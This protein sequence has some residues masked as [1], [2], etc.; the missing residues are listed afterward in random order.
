MLFRSGLDIKGV[1]HIYNYNIPKISNDYIHRIGRTARAG[2]EGKV[3]N[4]IS[5]EDYM[6]FRGIM[7][8]DLIKA[9]MKKEDIPE[10]EF[11]KISAPV[12]RNFSPRSFPQRRNS[13]PRGRYPKF[14]R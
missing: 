12:K 2:A 7:G 6:P 4:I 14:R 5:E 13:S 9:S 1:S 3:I 8:D 10:F 11:V